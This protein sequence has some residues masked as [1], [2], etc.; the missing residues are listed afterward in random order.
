MADTAA[1]AELVARARAGEDDAFAEL[2]RRHHAHVIGLCVS[3][4]GDEAAAED[5][6]QEAFLKAHRSLS[7]F[8]GDAAFSTWLYRIAANKCLD[9]RRK[10][11]REKSQSLDAL[12]DAEDGP[13]LERLLATEGPERSAADKQLVEAVLA[14]LPEAYRM[15]LT[16]R[17]V[18]GLDYK[19]I[20]EVMDCSLDSVKARLRRA[21]AEL[22]EKLRHF[23]GKGGV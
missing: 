9:A 16:L 7:A 12:L 14:E 13:S 11:A 22:L 18:S 1:D 20:A 23:A 17:E 5:A 8:R 10:L 3:M 6:A 2:V 21:R 19:E 15:I 4:L